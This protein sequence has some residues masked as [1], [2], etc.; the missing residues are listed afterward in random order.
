MSAKRYHAFIS[1]SHSA[2]GK[3]AP[4]LQKA[5]QQL[6]K[7]WYRRRSLEVFRDE[8]GLSVDP[9]LWGAIVTALDN[10]E[11]LLLLSSP[12][13]ARSEWVN[14]EIEHWKT[15]G[16][17]DRILP[18][19]TDGHWQW[20]PDRRDFSEDS[21]AVAPAL[22]GVFTDEPRHLDLRWARSDKQLDLRNSRFRDAVAELA[23]PMHGRTKDEIEG[24]DVRQHRR[25]LRIAWSATAALA[26]L[27]VA[28][29]VG[30]GVAVTNAH[31]A[32]DRRIDAE[33]Q[34][35]AAQSQAELVRP[36]LA[37]LL[38]AS[39]YRLR[40]NAQTEG[41]LLTT[42][43]NAP[44]VKQRVPVG[45]PVT[46]LATSA[47]ADRVW[48]GTADGDVIA[49]RF[50]DGQEMGRAEGLPAVGVIA[51]ARVPGATDSV[52]AADVASIR[53][54]DRDMLV[55][56]TRRS[57]VGLVSVAVDPGT[58]RIAAGTA[59]GT[60]LIWEA[61]GTDPF[62]TVS[63]T[64]NTTA[65][66]KAVTALAWTPDGDIIV[67]GT[68]GF[69]RVDPERPERPLWVHDDP[70]GVT[71]LT[72]MDDGTVVAGGNY[73]TVSFWNGDGSPAFGDSPKAFDDS[74]IQFA[75]TG[76]P[77]DQGSVAAVSSDGNLR[78]F[79]HLTGEP[80]QSAD[81]TLRIDEQD[82]SAVAWDPDAPIYGVAAGR[83]GA[84][85]LLDYGQAHPRP[86]RVAADWE[87]ATAV[88]LSPGQDRLVVSRKVMPADGKVDESGAGWLTEL[89]LTDA[90]DPNPHGQTV[91]FPG[92]VQQLGFSPDRS[93][94]VATTTDGAVAVWD[95]SSAQAEL[96]DV[97][98][99]QVISQLA[100]SPDGTTVATGALDFDSPL[101]EG[102][103]VQLWRVDGQK[104]VEAARFTTPP[105]SYG[106][107]F[108]PDGTRLV[109]GGWRAVAVQ[110][111]AGGDP[112]LIDIGDDSA[113][114]LAVTPDGKILAVGLT[115]GPVRLFDTATGAQDGDDLHGDARAT[116]LA[117][118]ADGR[119]L[120]TV[121]ES[122][123]FAIW[124]V[125]S[126]RQ[127]SEKTLFAFD[128]NLTATVTDPSL[129]V[130]EDRAYTTSFAD[131]QIVGW[132]LTP[133]EWISIG[134]EVFAR[135]LTDAEKE[136]FG[137]EGAA[138]ICG[139]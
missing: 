6:A 109:V 94:I 132:P 15:H 97:A 57:G 45:A 47:A 24:E 98:P 11:W 59:A 35:L 89:V 88:A 2:D 67:A 135:D 138:P 77:P 106:M 26:V 72:V 86:A 38:A 46:A 19:L 63:S 5:L 17:I 90:G 40:P 129:A 100:V 31:R 95:G 14:R 96:T 41:A 65:P 110:P 55:T 34:R 36:D 111:V 71:A 3:L 75:A 37:F 78:F 61:D 22:R 16:N 60:V 130:G 7:P 12:D 79:D 18:V 115:S 62:I 43:A 103:I 120:V 33:A 23:A 13:A 42:V 82:A 102:G 54:L 107:A 76:F 128:P 84:V 32:E 66:R 119:Q 28:A 48:V 68:T 27:T 134:C 108:T 39:G 87:D 64:P 137:L 50:S 56:T 1:Y 113:R 58:G 80:L 30:A 104:L 81:G 122:G 99:G 139:G 4:T 127:L 53:T 93:L 131:G 101:S 10:S 124:D 51:L 21:D 20:D 136:R 52:I 74:V 9:H 70:A 29:V 83:S 133:D 8:T 116:A 125:A 121:G 112:S 44:E 118:R 105:L 85:V 25:N 92:I 69:A 91:R 117:F 126:R 123:A 73:G 49:R 114:S